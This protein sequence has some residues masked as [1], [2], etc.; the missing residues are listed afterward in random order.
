M[1]STKSRYITYPA[2]ALSLAIVVFAGCGGGH[3]SSGSNNPPGGSLTSQT[4]SA[5][6]T[7]VGTRLIALTSPTGVI[8]RNGLL[9]YVS[10][11]SEFAQSGFTDDGNLFAVFKNNIP[12]IIIT[13]RL[14]SADNTDRAAALARAVTAVDVPTSKIAHL[15]YSFDAT[16]TDG[17]RKIQTLLQDW[18]YQATLASPEL[19]TLANGLQ[20]DGVVYW[21]AHG[22]HLTLPSGT[23]TYLQTATLADAAAI[24]SRMTRFADDFAHD[25]IALMVDQTI[26]RQN[27]APVTV[28]NSKFA[29]NEEFI[30]THKW[31]FGANSLVFI[32][33]CSSATP[34]FQQAFLTANAGLF[35]GWSNTVNDSD[36]VKIAPIVFDR[37]L[38]ANNATP[39]ENPKQR[40]FDFPAVQK[41]LHDNHLDL[42][43]STDKDGNSVTAQLTFSPG[44]GTFGLLAPTI[45]YMGM[46]ELK[47][48]LTINGIFGTDQSVAKVTVGGAEQAIKSWGFNSIVCDLQPGIA[49]DTIVEVRGHKSNTVQL[50]QWTVH[51]KTHMEDTL[52]GPLIQDGFLDVNFRADIHSH[53]DEPHQTPFVPIV[54]F[55]EELNSNGQY[56]ASG[57]LKGTDGKVLDTWSGTS[58]LQ[59]LG[60]TPGAKNILVCFGNIDVKNKKIDIA[61]LG[62]ASEG[63]FSTRPPEG[64]EPLP[65]TTGTLDGE[66]GG[67]DASAT[68]HLTLNDDFSINGGVREQLVGDLLLRLQWD[69]IVPT[70]PPAEQAARS[71]GI[72]TRRTP[73]LRPSAPRKNAG[74]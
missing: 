1:V 29:I 52:G 35:I 6:M 24:A 65:G 54:P 38:G 4:M 3:G 30:T 36:A 5:T 11:R 39:T 10:S 25:R 19:D 67:G 34:A 58:I 46:N 31:R 61:L 51:F 2:L 41:Y 28:S 60:G 43:Q 50:T 17:R 73:L 64:P 16:I 14:V 47:K 72:F 37:L 18:G 26:I 27:G 57:V 56:T 9:T 48:E 44:Q 45:S 12:V 32:N 20:G 55:N 40:A 69:K 70:S 7:D 15:Y 66:F 68:L 21:D 62:A 59:A 71:A 13:N 33:A 42:S 74:R 23:H 22:S 53:R 8:D 63:M 49:G